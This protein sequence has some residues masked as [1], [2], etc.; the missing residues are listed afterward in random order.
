MK[1]I[2]LNINNEFSKLKT[3][4]INPSSN[5]MFSSQVNSFINILKKHDVNTICADVIPNAK[6]QIFVRDPF[7]VID[8]KLVINF[9][10]ETERRIELPSAY[11]LLSTINPAQIIYSPY[12][13]S[14]EGG[15]VIP[16]N[17]ILF[18][19]QDGMRT[20]NAGFEFLK[21]T[22]SY[23]FDVLPVYMQI[24]TKKESW[25]HLDCVFNP[26][27][28]DT[29]LV[30]PQS[31]KKKSLCIIKNIFK[32]IIIVSEREKD[33][34]AVNVL[35]LGNNTII[36]QERH[37]RIANILKSKGFNIEYMNSYSTVEWTGYCRCM[38][39]PI[40]RE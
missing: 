35:S 24:N 2:I 5:E 10:K 19:G 39:C 4:F 29:A 6:Y 34:L 12:G 22:F 21:Q 26:I 37:S 15:D 27:S 8:D 25:S 33:E 1:N 14:I 32:N 7:M 20:D 16:C 13:I 11:P 40:E 38:S 9:M 31:I 36:M 23:K 18:V 30:F 17:K 28:D 3:V